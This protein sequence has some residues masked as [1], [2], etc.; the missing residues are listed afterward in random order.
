MAAMEEKDLCTHSKLKQEE[1]FRKKK[2]KKTKKTEGEKPEYNWRCAIHY[3]Y[4]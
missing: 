4:I 3:F 1:P 2:N